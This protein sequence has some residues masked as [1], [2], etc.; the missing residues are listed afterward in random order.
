[1][2]IWQIGQTLRAIIGVVNNPDQPVYTENG[3]V[4]DSPE[5]DAFAMNA[6]M[7]GV[8]CEERLVPLIQLCLANMPQRRP[9]PAQIL[10]V[11]ETARQDGRF[12]G[13]D[14]YGQGRLPEWRASRYRLKINM[15]DRYELGL[16]LRRRRAPKLVLPRLVQKRGRRT[17]VQ[18]IPA[19]V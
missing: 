14:T 5:P 9:R 19:P 4:I 12:D 16:S 18:A 17:T 1:M 10:Q 7:D 6:F 15:V 3:G 11:I 8:Y 13:M 2:N